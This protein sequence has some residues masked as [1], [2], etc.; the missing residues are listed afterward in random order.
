MGSFAYI[1]LKPT[2]ITSKITYFNL[3]KGGN[4]ELPGRGGGAES[5]PLVKIAFRTVFANF[6][7]TTF[8][9]YIH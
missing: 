4:L 1:I 8:Q 6:F 5:A 3:K 7:N 9:M 2:S